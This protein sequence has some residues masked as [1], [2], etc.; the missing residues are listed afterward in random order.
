MSSLRPH[1]ITLA[2]SSWL[3]AHANHGCVQVGGLPPPQLSSLGSEALK[4]IR[5]CVVEV[6]AGTWA[7][8]AGRRRSAEVPIERGKK[9]RKPWRIPAVAHRTHHSSLSFPRTQT[10]EDEKAHITA[11]PSQV[12]QSKKMTSCY[13]H[14]YYSIGGA[15]HDKGAYQCKLEDD[16]TKAAETLPAQPQPSVLPTM[17]MT[18][19]RAADIPPMQPMTTTTPGLRQ[20]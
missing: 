10:H 8:G 14:N 17:T 2:P 9:P 11:I 15:N 19:T 18:A 20:Q 13:C 16:T 6:V 5:E 4:H 1:I 3:A 12:P 7:H